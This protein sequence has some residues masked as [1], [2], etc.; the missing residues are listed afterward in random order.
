MTDKNRESA[1]EALAFA[2]AFIEIRK[3]GLELTCHKE[4][5]L[6]QTAMLETDSRLKVFTPEQ[7][8]KGCVEQNEDK[9]SS[10]VQYSCEELGE[11]VMRKSCGSIMPPEEVRE[12]LVKNG[13]LYIEETFFFPTERGKKFV[14][15]DSRTWPTFSQAFYDAIE[16]SRVSLETKK[17]NLAIEQLNKS[18]GF[19][20]VIEK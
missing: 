19:E 7:T 10:I 2:K 17:N 11:S 20:E 8:K 12:R 4:R 1:E 15:M 14:V 5:K 18:N 3:M 13:Y 9:P 6:F 16:T